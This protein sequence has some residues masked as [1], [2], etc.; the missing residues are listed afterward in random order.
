MTVQKLINQYQEK[1]TKK[2]LVIKKIASMITKA[3]NGKTNYDIE[4]LTF[5]KQN[6][7]RDRQLY[8]QFTKD[9]EDLI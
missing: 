1:I 9:L 7:Q 5:E 4:D 8:F 2:D 3:R 6:A